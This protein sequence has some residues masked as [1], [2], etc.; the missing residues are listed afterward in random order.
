MRWM[1]IRRQKTKQELDRSLTPWVV[2]VPYLRSKACS[3][4]L[5]SAVS[6]WKLATSRGCLRILN[7]TSSYWSSL[8]V[9]W[10]FASLV[11]KHEPRDLLLEIS[12]LC[13]L[14]I[15]DNVSYNKVQE[16]FFFDVSSSWLIWR[17]SRYSLGRCWRKGALIYCWWGWV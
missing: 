4:S 14:T 7:L 8:S 2:T 5:G 1:I 13:L 12:Q 3:K 16:Q 10:N 6:F 11:V 15:L 9:L 17:S